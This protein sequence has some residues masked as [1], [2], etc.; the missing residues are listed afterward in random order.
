LSLCSLQEKILPNNSFLQ[1]AVSYFKIDFH[2]IM[3]M[4]S[5]F[6]FFNIFIILIFCFLF[7]ITIVSDK[8]FQNIC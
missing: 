6:L 2:L 1:K 8:Y 5:I 7:L 4:L 3:L